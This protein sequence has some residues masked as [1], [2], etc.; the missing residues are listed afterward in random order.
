MATTQPACMK[1]KGGPP[2]TLPAEAKAVM[3]EFV[4]AVDEKKWDK[5]LILCTPQTQSRA[6]Q[7]GEEEYFRRCVPMAKL[8]AERTFRFWTYTKH[9]EEYRRF[10]CFLNLSKTPDGREI[11]WEWW[12]AHTAHGWKVDLPGVPVERWIQD[13][14]DRLKRDKERGEARWR[15]LEPKLEGLRTQLTALQREYRLGRPMPFLLELINEGEHE[16]SYDDQ[17][18]AVNESMI[19]K[20]EN[21]KV[22]PYTAGS[23]QTEGA[24]APIKPG[25]SVV[26]FESLDIARQYDMKKAGKYRVQ[27]SGR[28]LDVFDAIGSKNGAAR[29]EFPSNTVEIELKP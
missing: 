20:D 25:T 22:M 4:M 9:N 12:L 16:L 14:V 1:R 13:E 2:T 11:N 15:A 29:R 17:Q 21:G 24:P 5:A 3:D 26:L 28:G 18:V 6:S 10:G 7:Y 19:I 8:K 27:F 23:F